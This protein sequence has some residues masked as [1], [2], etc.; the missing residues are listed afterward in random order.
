MEKPLVPLSLD[1][2]EV[3]LWD[4]D[5]GKKKLKII[6]K[7][8]FPLDDVLKGIGVR[9]S[10]LIDSFGITDKEEIKD[11]LEL[12]KFLQANQEFRSWINEIDLAALKLP[13][14]EEHFLKYFD[15][16]KPHNPFWEKVNEFISLMSSF[17]I[18]PSRLKIV[19][20]FLTSSLAMEDLEKRMSQ[21][22]AEKIE[23]MAIIEGTIS[24]LVKIYDGKY[25]LESSREHVHGY[26]VYSSSI[27]NVKREPYPVFAGNKWN[28]LNWVGYSKRAKEKAKKAVDE[29]NNQKIEDVYKERI[30]LEIPDI[31]RKDI[32]DGIKGKLEESAESKKVDKMLDGMLIHVYFSYSRE[33]LN[34]RIYGVEP[35]NAREQLF[36]YTEFKGC[37]PEHTFKI[38]EAKIKMVEAMR[39][40]QN[41]LALSVLRKILSEK[42]PFLFSLTDFKGECPRTDTEHKW[43]AVQNL[44]KSYFLKD[45]YEA[46]CKIRSFFERHI[47]ILSDVARIVEILSKKAEELKTSLCYPEILEEGHHTVS[48]R[49]I[50]PVHLISKI[51][52]EDIVPIK[53]LPVLN[54]QI[55]GLTGYHGG[56]KTVTSLAVVTNIFLAQSGLPI[57]GQGF[58]LNVKDVLGMMFIEKGGGSTCELL[59]DKIVIILKEIKNIHNSKVVLVLDELGTGT[60]EMDGDKL[61]KDVLSK[62]SDMGVSVLFSTQIQSLAEF[63]RDELGAQCL[64]VDE[65]HGLS[66]GIGTGGMDSLRR[67]KGLDKLLK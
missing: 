20:D 42:Y 13:T 10:N 57:F 37:T 6:N 47:V 28:P 44:Y 31:L 17:Q 23:G 36:N 46:S 38:K 43:F 52:A 11:R 67:R 16:E 63:A 33:G 27:V 66:V 55:L 54:G 2:P 48:F 21:I 25:L 22:V 61:G 29:R 59:L 8:D 45:S 40:N 58:R 50:F 5:V 53:S 39:Q 14:Q 1:Y 24:L 30:I 7:N 49:E 34:L 3:A 64:K 12:A 56:G 35:S 19:R 41:S 51:K 15:T 62:L 32:I 9:H 26:Q 65:K 4:T 60:Q 18:I